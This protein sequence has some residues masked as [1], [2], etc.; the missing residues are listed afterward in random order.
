MDDG[1]EN[2][3]RAKLKLPPID[4]ATI[5]HADMGGAVMDPATGLPAAPFPARRRAAG[6]KPPA[7]SG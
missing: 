5:R 1:I 6:P 2:L 4:P 7:A 3:M